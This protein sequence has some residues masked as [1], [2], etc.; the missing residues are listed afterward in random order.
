MRPEVQQW[1]DQANADLESARFNQ[2]GERWYLVVF[3]CQQ[4]VE[5]ALKAYYLQ[6]HK[7]GPGNMHSLIFLAKE[8]KIP[9]K[10][11]RFLRELTPQFVNTRYPD[12][13]YG[14]PAELYDKSIAGETLKKTEEV[15]RWLA[16]RIGK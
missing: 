4:A 2:K 9:E 10:F 11:F 15:M 3:L 1:R 8:T 14:T 6:E 16:S 7:T 13:A 5:K 12:A